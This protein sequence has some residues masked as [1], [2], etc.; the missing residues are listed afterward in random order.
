[1]RLLRDAPPPDADPTMLL[2]L[3]ATVPVNIAIAFYERRRGE[4]LDSELL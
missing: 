3:A 2:V 4:E 1:A